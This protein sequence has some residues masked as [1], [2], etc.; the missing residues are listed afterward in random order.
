K[1]QN[2]QKMIN[3]IPEH[4]VRRVLLFLVKKKAPVTAAARSFEFDTCNRDNFLFYLPGFDDQD[5]HHAIVI[6]TSA[7]PAELCIYE[8]AVT[9]REDG[10]AFVMCEGDH[11]LFAAS[12]FCILEERLQA[13]DECSL[14]E[15]LLFEFL[16]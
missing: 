12:G 6:K 5:I 14:K 10:C 9:V 7:V 11:R 15:I 3:R 2:L 4:P 8:P 16:L 1:H 13:D